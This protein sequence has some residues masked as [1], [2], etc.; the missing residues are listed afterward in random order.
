MSHTDENINNETLNL[1]LGPSVSV[2]CKPGSRGSLESVAI[3]VQ[4]KSCLP[5]TN[6]SFKWGVPAERRHLAKD[7]GLIHD[8]VERLAAQLSEW[9]VKIQAQRAKQ[10]TPV[11]SPVLEV[12]CRQKT[13]DASDGTTHSVKSPDEMVA[14][15]RCTTMPDYTHVEWSP[16]LISQCAV[17]DI[18]FHAGSHPNHLELNCLMD[19]LSPA[20]RCAWIS[21]GMGLKAIYWPLA[22]EPF[23]ADELAAG[24]AAQM[25][26]HP[27]VVAH[28][29]TVEI[30]TQTRHP[31]CMHLMKS[32]VTKRCG[33]VKTRTP[34][35]TFEIMAR[36]SAAGATD[37]EVT[38]ASEKLDLRIGE[39][40]S[41]DRC[42]I[43]PEHRSSSPNPVMVSE[44]GLYC[45]SCQGRTDDGFRSWGSIRK[46]NGLELS[47]VPAAQP[48][49]D[50]AK[51]LVHYNHAD[52]LFEALLGEVPE[53]YRRMLY[54]A[55]LKIHH[56]D[57]MRIPSAFSDF[58]FV[59][60]PE[61]WLCAQTLRLVK[62]L[63]RQGVA[64]L[65][66]AQFIAQTEEG[67]EARPDPLKVES[68]I[69][70][71]RLEGW[72]PLVG[73]P[74][75]PIYFQH[76]AEE[77]LHPTTGILRVTPRKTY[78]ERRVSYVPPDKRL[79]LAECER[80]IC[81]YL[82]GV[83]LNYLKALIILTGVGESGKGALPVLWAKGETGAGKTIHINLVCS[84]YG[85]P[86]TSLSG[87][88][89][90][91]LAEGVG[92]AHEQSRLLLFDDPFK[93]PKKFAVLHRFWLQ[94]TNRQLPFHKLYVGSVNATINGAII[95][96]DRDDH[97]FFTNDKQF[98]RRCYRIHLRESV[99]DWQAMGRDAKTWWYTP[100]MKEAADGLHSHI[101][102]TFFAA[103]D[104]RGLGEKLAPFGVVRL[105]HEDGYDAAEDRERRWH[106]VTELVVQIVAD[107]GFKTD[108]KD[109]RH[110]GIG[111][112]EIKW[113]EQSGVSGLCTQLVESLGAVDLCYD[114]LKRVADDI[115]D[116]PFQTKDSM[117]VKLDVKA[118]GKSRIF[119]RLAQ[120]GLC[121]N[122]IRNSHRC[123]NA[124][125]FVMPLVNV[126][127][128]SPAVPSVTITPTIAVL[129]PALAALTAD[130]NTGST[131]VAEQ[132]MRKP[133]Y[134]QAQLPPGTDVFDFITKT[135]RGAGAIK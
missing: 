72:T 56:G 113:G 58:G 5:Y 93:D 48:L 130:T 18:D 26:I 127:M 17:L 91:K 122:V 14:L 59:R 8:D 116:W 53:Q 124:D 102:D 61:G 118:H 65:P 71:T 125:C 135:L 16:K 57:D 68:Y 131:P 101:V 12:M 87:L 121:G 50:A 85:E 133:K 42:V 20:P 13:Q 60:G 44:K 107:G 46:M 7:A 81:E 89:E 96:A 22:G 86:V 43:D 30:S 134:P 32:G 123:F 103:G 115:R 90:D 94:I 92:E 126:P 45:H 35:T 51:H 4:K 82:P 39:R 52:Y 63:S 70:V 36:L 40:L 27:E 64:C 77:A 62:P 98:G 69:N 104:Y 2:T 73:A 106:N 66:S 19:Q 1:E 120:D 117:R 132:Q 110:V 129:P 67:P 23:T 79:P 15:L 100:E 11:E 108:D 74:F 31:G 84:M 112:I 9:M 10:D 21:T 105:D 28:M 34:T 38:E 78:S 119:V 76:N 55:L 24:A 33:E 88:N 37:A 25:T 99:Q 3:R 97:G 6:T 41:H 111:F 95:I 128:P 109:A 47:T 49:V 83:N 114:N 75:V 54:S 29:G 80:R